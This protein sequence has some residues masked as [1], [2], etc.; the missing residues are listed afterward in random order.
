MK[1]TQNPM[2]RSQKCL[3]QA[4]AEHPPKHLRVPEVEPGEAGEDSRAHQHLVE[5]GHHEVRVVGREVHRWRGK[6]DAGDATDQEDEQEA[7]RRTAW[8]T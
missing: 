7:R 8:V 2:N 1:V 5:V 6:Q 4:L 3:G